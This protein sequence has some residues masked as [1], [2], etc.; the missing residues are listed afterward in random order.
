MTRVIQFGGI[1]VIAAV[2]LIL[3]FIVG[4]VIPLFR[5]PQIRPALTAVL[6]SDHR[7]AAMGM[8]DHAE[9]PFFASPTLD[10]LFLD[11]VGRGAAENRGAFYISPGLPDGFDTAVVDYNPRSGHLVAGSNDGRLAL[12]RVTYRTDFPDGGMR[13]TDAGLEPEGVFD[14]GVPDSPI[15][16]L[17]YGDG[18][19]RRLAAAVQSIDGAHRLFAL[20]IEQ[21]RTLLGEG[22]LIG[23]DEVDLTELVDGTPQHVLVPWE[24][25]AILVATAEGEV[26]YLFDDPNDGFGLRQ[27]FSPFSDLPNPGIATMDF[28]L[29][30]VSV[31]F[32][33]V[34]GATRTFSLY[35][36]PEQ[37]V[38]IW[39]HF[40]TFPPLGGGALFVSQSMRNR[41]FLI[42]EERFAAIRY[43]TTGR[44]RAEFDLPFTARLAI[45]GPRYNGM[46]FLDTENRVHW[47]EI[48][49]PHPRASWSTYFGRLRYEGQKEAGYV[50]QS[51]GAT[52]DFE[53]KLSMVPLIVGTLKGT[54][55][56]M[57]F[58]LPIALL[59]AIYTSQFLK[60]ELK[61]VVKPIME[62]MA[63]LPSV[64]LGFIAALWLAPLVSNAVP[65]AVTAVVCVVV[66]AFAAGTLHERLPPVVRRRVPEG[67]EFLAFA[68][69]MVLSAWLGWH[70]GA[71]VER[72]A[73]LVVDPTT[74]L[75]VADFRL[76]FTNVYGGEFEQ[77]NSLVV[78][79]VM[80]FAVIPLMFTIAEDSL[81][82]VPES[83]RSGSLALGASR[84]QTAIRVV[85]PTA[86]AGI[87]SAVMIGLGR[88]VGETMIVVMAT[89]NVP[90]TDFNIFTGMRTLSA[91]I[92][93]ELP[94]APWRSTL[95]RSLFLGSL[96]LFSFTFVVNTAA[97]I[98]RQG[99]RERFKAVE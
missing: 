21:E 55:Y 76:W 48:E 59:S 56:A 66:A 78:G 33:S 43:N 57:L 2:L 62:I 29:G 17:G 89:G 69:F 39:D 36:D 84:W 16:L 27:R 88:A 24:A 79:M 15:E 99:L 18:T 82:N 52:D 63:S 40:R 7:V 38:R 90:V 22:E 97:E 73:F 81:S 86:A 92:A 74:G 75:R 10:V 20:R 98:L 28:V 30:D 42:G 5:K 68:P 19:I 44:T 58:S 65:S 77:R 53:A 23:G 41:A 11:T 60:P 32:T 26:F 94:E 93:V 3:A 64:V 91:N 6:P 37:G 47:W 72:F 31:V 9:L 80:G 1:L 34:T 13:R 61:R 87:F 50:W 95:Y 51:S 4:E 85:V 70:L 35:R 45:L 49:D 96:L 12:V 54:L 8:D 71:W 14:I 67:W 25:D 83:F 46:L